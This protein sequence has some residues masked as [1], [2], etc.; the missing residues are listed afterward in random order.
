MY[1]GKNE[2]ELAKMYSQDN[3]V[4]QDI[5]YSRIADD[6][7]AKRQFLDSA[8][9]YAKTKMS[10]EEIALKFLTINENIPL[11]FYLKSR[12]NELNPATDQTQITLLVVW[13]VEL[14]LTE[15]NGPMS[16]P[17]LQTEF[18]G[19]LKEGPV[20]ATLK[21]NR[22]VFHEI[23]ASHG[24]NHNLAALTTLNQDFDAV[25][26]QHIN[27]NKFKEA[28][29]V[30]KRQNE[31]DLFYKYC[32]ILV[33]ELPKETIKLLK[34]QGRNLETIKLLPSF[35]CLNSDLHRKE[36]VKYLE[37]SIHSL[38]CQDPSI[39]NYL[40][41]LYAKNKENEKLITYFETQGKDMTMIPYDVHYALRMCKEFQIKEASVFLLCLLELWQQAV[42]LA[43]TVNVK[44][45]QHTASQPSDRDLKRKLWLIIGEFSFF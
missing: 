8:R 43:L 2:F 45:A 1:L 25:I 34:E 21:S 37:Y 10:F 29:D 39:H 16:S 31:T 3:P 22:K 18:E 11:I 32:P 44:L 6:Y 19:F 4:H 23:I 5:V 7:F 38:G 28:L 35:L 9:T 36:I 12:L 41:Q 14:Y 17:F 40:I 13:L 27:Q 26:N 42:E 30:L 33:E 24:D 20:K 15:L